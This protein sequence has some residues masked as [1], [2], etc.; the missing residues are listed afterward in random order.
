M[1]ATMGAAAAAACLALGCGPGAIKDVVGQPDTPEIPGKM[2]CKPGDISK[3]LSPLIIDWPSTLRG[4]LETVM[5]EQSVAVVKFS[6]DGVEVLTDCQIPGG[7]GYRGISPKEENTLIE[8]ADDIGANFGGVQFGAN[9]DFS[10]SAKLDLAT[11]TVG[12]RSTPRKV[13]TKGELGDYCEGATH[14]VRRADIGAFAMSTGSDVQAGAALQ[15]FGQGMSGSSSSKEAKTNK[16]GDPKACKGA[17]RKAEDAPS[18]CGALIRVTL[19]PIEDGDVAAA[20]KDKGKVDDGIGCP[21]GF[22]YAENKCIKQAEVSKVK[23]FLCDEGNEAQCAEQCKKGSYASCDRLASIFRIELDEKGSPDTAKMAPFAQQFMAACE[24]D[25]ANACMLA[26]A[27]VMFDSM[28]EIG[29]AEG[30]DDVSKE[31]LGNIKTAFQ[32]FEQACIAGDRE[33]CDELRQIYLAEDE[34]QAEFAQMVFGEADMKSVYRKL[35]QRGCDAGSAGACEELFTLTMDGKLGEVSA[36]DRTAAGERACIGGFAQA[37]LVTAILLQPDTASCEKTF[38]SVPDL[39]E[40]CSND[41]SLF[42][43][44]AKKADYLIRRGCGLDAEMGAL[45]ICK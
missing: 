16:D 35:L 12:K 28:E 7:Y 11:V 26:G 42:P 37:C 17:D 43:S 4:D 22:V 31:T 18:G 30:P 34:G 23:H 25:F 3:K 13:L 33:S 9:V 20:K 27:A 24:D 41:L 40:V 39:A 5:A 10:Q 1:K 6:C 21:T 45:P 36:A 2:E 32:Y 8:G 15:V 19:M 38:G 29:N 14:F 44:D